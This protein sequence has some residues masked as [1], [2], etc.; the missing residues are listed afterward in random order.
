MRKNLLEYLENSAARYPDRVA[1]TNGETGLTFQALSAAARAVGSALSEYGRRRPVAVLMPKQADMV[2]ALLGVLYS[3]NY[4]VPAD[5]EMSAPRLQKILTAAEPAALVCDAGSE[6]R[7]RELGCAGPVRLYEELR[8]APADDGL[9]ARIRAQALDI[10]PAYVVF[11]SGSTGAPKGVIA[12]HRNAL[13]YIEQLSAVLEAD[14]GTVFGSQ[15][16]FYVDA[17]LKELYTT[18]KC[19]A[20]TVIIPKT[21]FTSPVRLIAFLNEHRVNT[22]CWVSSALTIVSS[23]GGLKAATPEYL[24]LIAFGSET[25]PLRQFELW[26]AALPDVKYIHLYGPTEAT[27]MSCYYVIEPGA[28]LPREKIP[29]G[30]PFSNTGVLL[31]DEA[32]H[33][34]TEPGRVGEMYIRGA[35]VT[36]GYF[37]DR[38]R[39]GEAFV[40]NPLQGDYPEIVYRTGDRACYDGEGALVFAA[41]AD[42]QIKHMGYRIELAEIE[43]AA[44]ACGAVDACCVFDEQTSRMT[45]F[46]LSEET[47]ASLRRRLKEQLPAYMLPAAVVNCA[48]FPLTINGKIDRAAL[49]K[50]AAGRGAGGGGTDRRRKE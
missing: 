12:S 49:K 39:T 18:L 5:W 30:F 15:T 11:T 13:D 41:R 36:M 35:G 17:C 26:R 3:G 34:I 50:R 28:P 40:Q 9:L 33:L 42:Q 29:I 1:F 21:L 25:F 46:C 43:E 4:Y 19:G 27:G 23:L 32:N 14:P 24:R 48:A 22:I 47:E 6:A 38:P 7:L 10:D 8:A 44:R 2:A 16:P 37:R 45:L 20:Q 31:I